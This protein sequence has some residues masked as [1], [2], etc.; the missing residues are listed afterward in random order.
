MMSLN[1]TLK[2]QCDLQKIMRNRLKKWLKLGTVYVGKKYESLS[3][4]SNKQ[5]ATTKVLYQ[6]KIEPNNINRL[7]QA[8]REWV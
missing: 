5:R 3:E 7:S 2:K 6:K 4:A 1:K 8:C